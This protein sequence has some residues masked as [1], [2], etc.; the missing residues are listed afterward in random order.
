MKENQRRTSISKEVNYFLKYIFLDQNVADQILFIY[1]NFR[2]KVLHN[3]NT[4]MTLTLPILLTFFLGDII[5]LL[6]HE[7]IK[8][9]ILF[10]DNYSYRPSHDI[11]TRSSLGTSLRCPGTSTIHSSVLIDRN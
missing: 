8:K 1:L 2:E 7:L 10:S 11:S 9:L 5:N 4:K 3:A 6:D